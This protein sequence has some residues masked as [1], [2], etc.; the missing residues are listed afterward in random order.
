MAT[1]L[2]FQLIYGPD[3]PLDS[4]QVV[5]SGTSVSN[6]IS[7]ENIG[8]GLRLYSVDQE[9]YYYTYLDGGGGVEAVLQDGVVYTDS[10][11]NSVIESNPGSGEVAFSTYIQNDSANLENG[12]H[13]Y[14]PNASTDGRG[15]Y[16]TD[17]ANGKWKYA[18]PRFDTG[19]ETTESVGGLSSGTTFNKGDLV[20]DAIIGMFFSYTGSNL[21]QFRYVSSN[22]QE[23]GSTLNSDIDLRWDKNDAGDANY[24]QI[25]DNNDTAVYDDQSPPSGDIDVAYSG[26]SVTKSSY[27]T[28]TYDG[29]VDYKEGPVQNGQSNPPGPGQ[30]SA[31]FALKWRYYFWYVAQTDNPDF[32]LTDPANTSVSSSNVRGLA[33]NQFTVGSQHAQFVDGTNIITF[34]VRKSKTLDKINIKDTELGQSDNYTFSFSEGSSSSGTDDSYDAG[35]MYY[36]EVGVSLPDNSTQA[37]NVYQWQS[38]N[39]DVYPSN[40]NNNKTKLTWH[41]S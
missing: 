31:S 14:L 17:V 29:I 39:L 15:Y 21:H 4:K 19:F 27:T 8:P 40:E 23:V 30:D 16:I 9:Q 12:D 32:D 24:V 37:Y 38:V 36:K 5:P 33:N 10:S 6:Y 22:T 35:T 11:G 13:I 20:Q 26:L 3:G 25:L 18:E 1:K 28:L 41:V 34:A 7:N 2:P